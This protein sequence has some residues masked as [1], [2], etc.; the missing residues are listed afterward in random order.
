MY[1]TDRVFKGNIVRSNS[2]RILQRQYPHA[3]KSVPSVKSQAKLII[4]S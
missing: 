1:I 4:I 2:E 3:N